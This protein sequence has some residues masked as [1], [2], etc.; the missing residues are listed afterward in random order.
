MQANLL[1]LAVL[2]SFSARCSLY[3][4]CKVTTM[5]FCSLRN[6]HGALRK[7]TCSRL[8][9]RAWFLISSA[10]LREAQTRNTPVL[11]VLWLPVKGAWC[12]NLSETYYWCRQNQYRFFSEKKYCIS[13][14][15][16]TVLWRDLESRKRG[17]WKPH[18]TAQSVNNCT[19]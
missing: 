5:R 3:G 13:R 19:F 10:T 1:L 16:L 15:L 8:L 18:Y 4:R 17:F 12:H 14:L 6:K 9:H 2:F 11:F 7:C